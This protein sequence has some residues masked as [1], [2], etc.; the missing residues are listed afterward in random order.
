[1]QSQMLGKILSNRYL[2]DEE[3]GIG[4]MGSVY[5]AT[6]L[7]TGGHVAV[8]IPHPQIARDGEY[9]ERLRREAQ[10]A[11]SLYSPR[12]VRVIDLDEQEGVPFLVM[13]YVPGLTLHDVLRERGALSVEESTVLGLEIARALDVAC[14]KGIVHRDLKPQNIKLVDGEVKVLDFGIAKAEGFAGLTAASV[15][16]GTP[17]YAAPERADGLGDIRSDIYAVGVIIYEALTGSLPFTGP[18]PLAVLRKH[19]T[20]PLPPLPESVP[21]PLRQ[22]VTRCLAK[23]PDDRY[24]LPRAL[25][26]DFNAA[27]RGQPL[28]S[29]QPQAEEPPAGAGGPAD[30]EKP[31]TDAVSLLGVG[32]STPGAE[33]TVPVSRPTARPTGPPKAPSAPGTM[34]AGAAGL[35]P[36][37]EMPSA[38][39]LAPASQAAPGALRRG[40][41]SRTALIAGGGAAMLFLLA[42]TGFLLLWGRGDSAATVTPVATTLAEAPPAST[43]TPAA[44]APPTTAPTALPSVAPTA[45]PSA[46]RPPATSTAVVPTRPVVVARIPAEAGKNETEQAVIDALNGALAAQVEAFRRVDPTGLSRYFTGQ[47]LADTSADVAASLKAQGR[48]AIADLTKIELLSLSVSAPDNATAK[49][50]ESYEYDEYQRDTGERVPGVGYSSTQRY[51]Y[52]FVKQENR[53]LIRMQDPPESESFV[54]R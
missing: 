48:Y 28:P 1:M 31:D 37:T 46:S 23:Q 10:I 11:A 44:I 17:E 42:L 5:R 8:K 50:R 6:D 45:A 25:V 36:L 21:E 49:T 14:A 22:I 2:L 53:W 54:G 18:S 20:A 29:L 13:E 40:G 51:T 3:I 19:E 26:Q 7:R 30:G 24:Q 12:I 15:F 52:H 27:L 43:P 39:S 9:L 34:L 35:P 4:G 38:Q 47:A 16:M 41:L 32:M 33:R